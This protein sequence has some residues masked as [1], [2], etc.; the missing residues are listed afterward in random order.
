MA[1]DTAK[2]AGAEPKP[3]RVGGGRSSPRPVALYLFALVLAILVPALAVALVLLNRSNDAQQDVVRAL[4]NATVQAIG[5]SVDREISSMATALRVLSTTQSLRDGD[6]PTFHSR[7]LQALA[8]TGSYLIAVNDRFAQLLNTRV[9]FGEPLSV[10]SDRQA[11]ARAIERGTTT[12]SGVFFG[13][14]AQAPVFTVWLPVDNVTPVRL[15]GLTQNARNLVPALQSRQLPE[16]W[17]AALVDSDSVIIAAT[18]DAELEAGT[19]LHLRQGVSLPSPDS[20]T[21]E[22]FNDESVVTAEWRSGLTGWRIVA[23]AA[24]A[25]VTRPLEESLL[26]LAAWGLV[27]AIAASAVAFLIA[28]R[29]GRSVQGL[30]RDAQRLG[31]GE[32]VFPRSYPVSEIAD[33]SQAL[34]EA[35]QQRL[36]AERD[37]RFLMRELAHRSKNQMAVIAAMAKQTARNATSVSQFVSAF[38]RRI[39][40]LARSTDLLLASGMVGVNLKDIIVGQIEPFKPQDPERVTIEGPPLMLNTQASQIVGMAAHELATNAVKYGAFA[41]DSGQLEVTWTISGDVVDLNWRERVKARRRRSTRTGFGTTVLN[42]MVGGS[43]GAEV[44]RTLHRDG[45]EWRFV[46]PLEALNPN[47]RPDEQLAPQRREESEDSPAEPP[48]A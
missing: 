17:H 5:Q 27:I 3:P 22:R 18:P 15:L 31:R 9:A 41:D 38:E 30:R 40:G 34:A 8:G 33:V 12:T 14:T 44:T 10:V 23:W 46:I 42:S 35:S 6:L 47:R 7:A 26:Q 48:A 20:W 32:S 16:G 36:T 37:I 2:T 45:I 28:Q 11:P 4:T 19:S 43:L 39:F 29:I 13:H 24:S 1:D 21:Q 25:Q